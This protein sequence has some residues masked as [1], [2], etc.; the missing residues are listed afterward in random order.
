MKV[1]IVGAGISGLYICKKLKEKYKD[2]EIHIFERAQQT[3]GKIRS[4]CLHEEILEKGAWRIS[5]DHSR[6]IKLMDVDTTKIPTHAKAANNETRYFW[7]PKTIKPKT[8]Q[9]KP[10]SDI[11]VYFDGT[12]P[13]NEERKRDY[14]K[15]HK[16]SKIVF[17]RNRAID[18]SGWVHLHPGGPKII[19]DIEKYAVDFDISER[20]DNAHLN[21]HAF[22]Q[23]MALQ[24]E[25]NLTES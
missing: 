14:E 23:L 2:I 18:V 20:F 8:P 4:A 24:V 1:A 10:K 25:V 7:Y 11:S 19:Q 5:D 13:T 21:D 3:G 6:M 12:K 17:Y 22:G 15:R 16:G 9:H